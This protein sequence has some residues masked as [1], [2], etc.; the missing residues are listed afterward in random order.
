M[1]LTL[2]FALA[3]MWI[4]AILLIVFSFELTV[5]VLAFINRKKPFCKCP[6]DCCSTPD[7]D[8]DAQ[9]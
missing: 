6:T 7:E 3:H 4:F 9:A 8:N 5:L 2:D 1:D